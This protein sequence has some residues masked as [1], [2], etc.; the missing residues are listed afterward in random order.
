[1]TCP[2]APGVPDGQKMMVL[3][4]LYSARS[5]MRTV[6]APRGGGSCGGGWRAT[7]SN[8]PCVAAGVS[9]LPLVDVPLPDPPERPLFSS[10]AKFADGCVSWLRQSRMRCVWPALAG[11]LAGNTSRVPRRPAATDCSPMVSCIRRGIFDPPPPH[12]HFP[13]CP[14]IANSTNL[15]KSFVLEPLYDGDISS[16]H[17]ATCRA[18]GEKVVIKSFKREKLEARIDLQ[19]KAC[20]GCGI[21]AGCRFWRGSCRRC[22]A[23]R[24]RRPSPPSL[25]TTPPCPTPQTHSLMAPLPLHSPSGLSMCP[26]KA[27]VGVTRRPCSPQRHHCFPGY[28]GRSGC[29]AVHGICRRQRRILLHQRKAAPQPARG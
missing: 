26:G 20:G 6:L 2:R 27:G 17:I 18:N 10:R 12:T 22:P 29:A 19:N 9:S 21:S 11:S 7:A 14:S 15:D 23:S 3:H 8:R 13:G 5:A 4:H 25:D 24:A 16:V 28:G 1:M